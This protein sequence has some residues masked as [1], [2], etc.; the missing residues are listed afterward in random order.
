MS[1]EIAPAMLARSAAWPIE[2]LLPFCSPALRDAG[3]RAAMC[4]AGYQI[5]LERESALLRERTLADPVFMKALLV[6]SPGAFFRARREQAGSSRRSR[7]ARQLETT[8][9]RYLARASARPTPNALWAG[10]ALARFGDRDEVIPGRPL[11]DFTP[12]LMPFGA[13]LHALSSRPEYRAAMR[14]RLGPTVRRQSDGNWRFLARMSDGS[15]DERQLASNALIDPLIERLGNAG[16]CSLGEFEARAR[17]PADVL[18]RLV[19]GGVL[20]GGLGLPVRFASPWTALESAGDMLLGAHRSAWASTVRCIADVARD[21]AMGF[22]AVTVEALQS[23]LARTRV[24]VADLFAGLELDIGP[25]RSALRCDLR[26]PFDLTIGPDTQRQILATI[27]AYQAEWLD[28]LSPQAEAWRQERKHLADHLA[29]SSVHVGEPLPEFHGHAGAACDA[30]AK[31]FLGRGE[32]IRLEA[33]SEKYPEFAPPWGCAMVRLGPAGVTRILGVDHSP[34]RP[35]SRHCRMLGDASG[36][37][38]WIGEV[39]AR[40]ERTHGIRIGDLG[41]A[42]ERNPNVLERP[43]GGRP[44]VAPWCADGVDLR[45]A[46][47][48]NLG[49]AIVFDVPSLG[50]LSVV[51]CSA[52]RFLTGDPLASAIALSGFDRPVGTG[53]HGPRLSVPGESIEARYAPRLLLSSGAMLR[54][55]RT[56]LEGDTLAQITTVSRRERFRRWRAMAEKH[57]WPEFVAL[58]LDQGPPLLLSTSSPLALE[59]AF[60]GSRGTRTAVVEEAEMAAGIEHDGRH[61]VTDLLVPFARDLHAFSAVV[62][63]DA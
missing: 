60:A 34:V 19:E 48:R 57:E 62:R 6:A 14:Y 10:V 9:Y 16:D 63:R 33:A 52:A 42:F 20:V 30:W 32:E 31:S 38:R 2:T 47:L 46:R 59:A 8:L 11:A 23:G 56:C 1:L 37:G 35:I 17:I 58:S 22:D 45:G 21:L 5:A 41:V 44:L 43:D 15:V 7:S 50:C 24:A 29:R 55:R 13:A 54:P 12:D 53:C 27:S 39:Q 61:F 40:L 3:E 51:S 28:R 36:I 4:D 18:S 26:L 49:G 25:G